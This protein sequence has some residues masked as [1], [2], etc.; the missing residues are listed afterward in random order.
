MRYAPVLLALILCGCAP[1]PI[2][3][4]A[5]CLLFPYV[6]P[7]DMADVLP[8]RPMTMHG[9]FI[10]GNPCRIYLDAPLNPSHL[11][12]IHEYQHY[13]EWSLRAYPDALRASRHAFRGMM[14]DGFEFG[15]SDLMTEIP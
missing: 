8:G 7:G 1:R 6:S 14:A 9:M 12:A 11:S 3:E 4:G 10:P 15:R 5:S 2:N 13:M